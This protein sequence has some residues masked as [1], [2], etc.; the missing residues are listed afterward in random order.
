MKK[1]RTKFVKGAN[2]NK[3]ENAVLKMQRH[4]ALLTERSDH[5]DGSS[6]HGNVPMEHL[7]TPLM[8]ALLD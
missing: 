3:K 1:V 4:Q 5:F 2:I 6:Y 7:L 8:F